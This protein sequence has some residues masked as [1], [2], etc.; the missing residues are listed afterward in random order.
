M[1]W[2]NEPAGPR[3]NDVFAIL[4]YENENS[5]NDNGN[6]DPALDRESQNMFD[7]IVNEISETTMYLTC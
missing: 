7:K 2:K 3:G 1:K 4:D 5:D 6:F